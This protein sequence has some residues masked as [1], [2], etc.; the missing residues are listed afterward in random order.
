VRNTSFQG[1][2]ILSTPKGNRR[3]DPEVEERPFARLDLEQHHEF[4]VIPLSSIPRVP[5]S[6]T[7]GPRTQESE[8]TLLCEATP[9]RPDTK[10]SPAIF[11]TP[12]TAQTNSPLRLPDMFLGAGSQNYRG[13]PR[14]PLQTRHSARQQYLDIPNSFAQT[15]ECTPSKD[16]AVHA[17][18]VKQ[19]KLNFVAYSN[20]RETIIEGGDIDETENTGKSDTQ[21]GRE[22]DSIYKS[23]G[24]DDYDE[25][26]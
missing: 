18:P 12:S 4:D 25:L 7:C 3:K 8:K 9:A 19:G 23:L 2:Q 11:G 21:R 24:W 13:L 1:V 17:T 22:D 20:S 26:T 6:A 14:S 16:V 10:I 15:V 5:L